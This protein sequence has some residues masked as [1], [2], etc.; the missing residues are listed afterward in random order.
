MPPKRCICIFKGGIKKRSI[1]VIFKVMTVH[2]RRQSKSRMSAANASVPG[3]CFPLGKL[4]FTKIP[5]WR[6]SKILHLCLL[7]RSSNC[8]Y[9]FISFILGHSKG[10]P[11]TLTL[12]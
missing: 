12:I 8:V 7:D 10:Q 6:I 9:Y 4:H 5:V 11:D 1:A 3:L 2:A